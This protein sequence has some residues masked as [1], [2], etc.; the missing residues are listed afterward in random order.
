MIYLKTLISDGIY[1]VKCYDD[2]GVDKTSEYNVKSK[3]Y[4]KDGNTDYTFLLET[5]QSTLELHPDIF[6]TSDY[7]YVTVIIDDVTYK[8]YLKTK[9]IN[10]TSV[11]KYTILYK[12]QTPLVEVSTP[13]LDRFNYFMPRWSTAYKND[14]SNYSKITYPLFAN[15]EKAFFKTSHIVSDSLINKTTT[16]KVTSYRQKIG[17]VVGADGVERKF[18]YNI[19]NSPITRIKEQEALFKTLDFKRIN[20]EDFVNV[21]NFKKKCS[22]LYVESPLNT[23]V[24]FTGLTENNVVV[25]EDFEF[26]T[27]VVKQS[28]HTYRKIFHFESSSKET[29]LSNFIDCDKIHLVEKPEK[30]PAF[31]DSNKEQQFPSLE[32]HEN[33]L[34]VR[35]VKDGLFGYDAYAY[36]LNR[37]FKSAFVT[38]TLDF[39]GIDT[40]NKLYTGILRKNLEVNMPLLDNNNNNP[41]VFVSSTTHDSVSFSVKTQDILADLET[42]IVTIKIQ[43][44]KGTHYIDSN[45]EQFTDKPVN[46]FLDSVNS[47]D[48]TLGIV[49]SAEFISVIISTDKRQYQASY[50]SDNITLTERADNVDSLRYINDELYIERQGV[51][52]KL[53][54]LKDYYETALDDSLI[55]YEDGLTVYSLKGVK[56]DG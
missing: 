41:Y 33:L 15:I 9:V 55:S 7:L 4:R 17:K 12:S 36:N 3:I 49:G 48:F 42:N 39:I 30:L 51:Y 35:F 56:I 25:T 27:L 22:R 53:V 26:N 10:E 32:L 18:T 6:E 45:T 19:E 28:K 16:K 54:L 2:S 1:S 38:D 34:N 46:Y 40:N 37:S 29:Y 23:T 11:L 5:T 50:R 24:T 13:F 43:T 8:T 31:I 52:S 14:V 47:L 44:D 20:V 21:I